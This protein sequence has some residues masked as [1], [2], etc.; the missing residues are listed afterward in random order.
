MVIRHVPT[1]KLVVL[2]KLL[3]K[4]ISPKGPPV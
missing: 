4:F 3:Q 1:G 2:K